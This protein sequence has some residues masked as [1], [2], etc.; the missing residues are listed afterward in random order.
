MNP[1]LTRDS[2]CAY[3]GGT[4]DPRYHFCTHCATV[5]RDPTASVYEEIPKP[6]LSIETRIMTSARSAWNFFC[7]IAIGLVA[8]GFVGAI[9]GE[10]NMV[11]TMALQEI[12]LITLT[13]GYLAY[14]WREVSFLFHRFKLNW[15]A[16]ASF[17]ILAVCLVINKVYHDFLTSLLDLDDSTALAPLL[18]AFPPW[19]LVLSICVFP[20]IVEEL[21]FRAVVQERMVRAVGTV[22]GFGATSV[23][24]TALHFS[25]LSAPYLFMLSM[26]LCW[27]RARTETIYLPMV[28]HFLHNFVVLVVF[29]GVTP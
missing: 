10:E 16:A 25:V 7:L 26:F 22:V 20:G 4:L 28:L 12:F 24:F 9:L 15:V 8:L 13:I 3:C 2:T 11:V 19:A 21:G 1:T 14:H 27:V 23:L 18:E 6:K 17:P 5:H 29:Y